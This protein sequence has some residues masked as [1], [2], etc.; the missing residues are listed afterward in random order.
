MRANTRNNIHIK[1][2]ERNVY[3]QNYANF[4]I[5]NS[6]KFNFFMEYIS[7]M[8]LEVFAKKYS[9]RNLTKYEHFNNLLVILM[10]ALS[11]T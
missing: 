10:K 8:C 3:V 9:K 6:Q 2:Y 1:K 5:F 7:E 4:I 11:Y